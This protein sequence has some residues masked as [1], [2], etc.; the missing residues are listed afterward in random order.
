VPMVPAFCLLGADYRYLIK[1]LEPMKVPRGGEEEAA[2]AWVTVLEGVVREHPT[3]W[4]NFFDI[5]NPVPA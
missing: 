1:V 4:F 3:Q 5:W 2:R